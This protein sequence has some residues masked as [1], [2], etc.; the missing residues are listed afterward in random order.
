MENQT[1]QIT[2]N[3]K[4]KRVDDETRIF[5]NY[6]PTTILSDSEIIKNIK[7]KLGASSVQNVFEKLHLLLEINNSWHQ[8]YFLLHEI[9]STSQEIDEIDKEIEISNTAIKLWKSDPKNSLFEQNDVGIYRK[10]IKENNEKKSQLTNKLKRIR[11]GLSYYEEINSR[12]NKA[13]YVQNIEYKV[14][15]KRALEG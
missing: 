9:E 1:Q 7:E 11:K 10:I 15:S 4:R 3:N 8:D 6:G 14:Q 5:P 2:E 12:K 13:E